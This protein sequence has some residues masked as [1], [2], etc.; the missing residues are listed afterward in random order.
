[1]NRQQ[2]QGRYAKASEVVDRRFMPER[3]GGSA[4]MLRD[5]FEPPGQTAQMRFINHR[6]GPRY[7]GRP[8][9]APIELIG[10]DHAF[11]DGKGTVAAVE[12]QIDPRRSEPVAV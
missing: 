1:M 6:V 9:L 5:V 7:T 10:R 11:S 4:I 8:I 3:G 2:F 12:R